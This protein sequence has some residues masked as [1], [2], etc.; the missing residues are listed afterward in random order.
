MVW[1]PERHRQYQC[2]WT[3]ASTQ[4]H[5]LFLGINLP[6]DLFC[7][8]F[9]F[10]LHIFSHHEGIGACLCAALWA[11]WSEENQMTAHKSGKHG[12]DKVSFRHHVTEH[13]TSTQEI[14]GTDPSIAEPWCITDT[15]QMFAAFAPLPDSSVVSGQS[16]IYLATRFFFSA[17]QLLI[18]ILATIL[19]PLLQLLALPPL[20]RNLFF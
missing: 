6:L 12:W 7:F 10:T 1:T 17:W 2:K 3:A 14:K 4:A 9:V 5:W 8:V 19:I 20:K 15:R 13:K 11:K 16:S 18:S